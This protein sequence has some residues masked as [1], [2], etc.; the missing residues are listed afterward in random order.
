MG[1]LAELLSPNTHAKTGLARIFSIAIECAEPRPGL[2]RAYFEEQRNGLAKM[3][4]QKSSFTNSVGFHGE[5]LS[6]NI[7]RISMHNNGFVTIYEF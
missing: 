6:N 1:E 2:S 5:N 4:Q 3:G 7:Q